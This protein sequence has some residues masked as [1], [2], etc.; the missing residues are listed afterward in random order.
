MGFIGG[1]RIFKIG[2]TISFQGI[3]L[4]KTGIIIYIEALQRTEVENEL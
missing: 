1:E 3:T 4:S 2:L